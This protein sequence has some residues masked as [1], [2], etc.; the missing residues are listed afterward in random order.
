MKTLRALLRTL[1]IVAG[2]SGLAACSVAPPEGVVPVTGFEADRYLGRWYEIARLDHSFERGMTDVHATYRRL[3]N[4]GIEVVNRGYD[5]ARQAWKEAVGHALFLG[6]PG[7]ASLKVSF[8]GPFYGGYHVV[9]LD[10]DAYRWALVAGP[11]RDYLWILARE[12]SIDDDVRDRL[13]AR[14]GA[15]GFDTAALIWVEQRQSAEPAQ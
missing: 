11:S 13:T 8:F 1:L 12:R 6:D 10:R 4:G 15:L 5:P 9:E 2:L 7:T 3:E 14:A